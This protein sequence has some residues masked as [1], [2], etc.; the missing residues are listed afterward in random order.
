[1]ETACISIVVRFDRDDVTPEDIAAALNASERIEAT[2]EAKVSSVVIALEPALVFDG[3]G[4]T[5]QLYGMIGELMPLVKSA[6]R[7]KA[8]E[9]ADMREVER[10]EQA[11][12]EL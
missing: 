5:D 3:R 8:H 2:C 11:G 7:A 9:A 1:M 12:R 10:L 4:A 6:L